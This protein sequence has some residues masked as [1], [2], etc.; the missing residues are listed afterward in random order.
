[1]TCLRRSAER[2]LCAD[3]LQA[4]QVL[5]EQHVVLDKF[6]ARRPLELPVQLGQSR[7][8][9]HVLEGLQ[10]LVQILK[11]SLI[12]LFMLQL[13]QVDALRSCPG[14]AGQALHQ[15]LGTVSRVNS[16]GALE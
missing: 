15:L 11:Q 1:M 7:E 3:V 8:H 13:L 5:T 4:S 9:S 6:L 16:R 2:Q 12:T 10:L 14:R